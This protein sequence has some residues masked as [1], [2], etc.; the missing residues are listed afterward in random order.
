MQKFVTIGLRCQDLRHGVVEEHLTEPLAQGWYVASVT[1]LGSP[2][3]AKSEV[4]LV[5]VVLEK[6][7][8]VGQGQSLAAGQMAPVFEYPQ[9]EEGYPVEPSG[10]AVG[11]DTP[12]EVGSRVLSFSQG[13]WWRAEVVGLERGGRVKIH[14]PGWDD[15]WDAVV[16]RKELQ[17]DLQASDEDE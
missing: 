5:A 13:R 1:A 10:V 9:D 14:F 8:P 16:P 17:V 15:K 3:Q 12:L 2:S 6:E 4:V 11:P 7:T